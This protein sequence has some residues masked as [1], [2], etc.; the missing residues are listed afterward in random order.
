MRT[1]KVFRVPEPVPGRDAAA[2][3]RRQLPRA[4]RR[5]GRCGPGV[6]PADRVLGHKPS[7]ATAAK[8][9]FV[10]NRVGDV[11][12]AIALMVMFAYI[13]SISFAGV[14]TAAPFLSEGTLTAIGLLLLLAACGKSAQVPLQSWLGD[15]MEGPTPGVGADPRR[16][17]GDRGCLPDRAVRPGLRPRAERA[18]G[19]R[20][21]RRGHAV[22][23]R[24]RRLRQG[25]HQESACRVDDVPDRLHGAGR[26]PGP[27]RLRVRDH[28]PADPRLLQGRACSSAPVR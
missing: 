11:G 3:A 25:R 9:A 14:F 15:A 1:A 22:V 13:G 27:G 26:G 2:G 20:D 4:V 17:D 7:A 8:K 16:H 5:V 10:V 24:D 21:R 6:L 28:A 23:R 18:T 12:L 19:R